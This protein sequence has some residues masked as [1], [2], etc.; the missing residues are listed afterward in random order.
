MPIKDTQFD[1][2]KIPG[3]SWPFGEATGITEWLIV[4]QDPVTPTYFA[5]V[6]AM[7]Y[8]IP[9]SLTRI[10]DEDLHLDHNRGKGRG[11][12]RGGNK[13]GE[14]K[15]L[16]G[17]FRPRVNIH[18]SVYNGRR[19]VLGHGPHVY[20]SRVVGLSEELNFPGVDTP[21]K[22]DFFGRSMGRFLLGVIGLNFMI[23]SGNSKGVL[24]CLIAQS[25]DEYKRNAFPS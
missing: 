5:P 15:L 21:F 24:I 11:K 7:L 14:K 20:F 4:I 22:N 10:E 25:F 16:K 19:P 18:S 1:E 3:L 13:P 17:G 6:H 9:D 23:T 2:D 12:G 8:N